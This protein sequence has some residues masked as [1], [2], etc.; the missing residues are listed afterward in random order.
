MHSKGERKNMLL[1]LGFYVLDT[2][3]DS[4]LNPNLAACDFIKK[5]DVS[6]LR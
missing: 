5:K 2:L 4:K 1:K 6:I 3:K